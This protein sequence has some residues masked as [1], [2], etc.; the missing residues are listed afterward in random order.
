M[1]KTIRQRKSVKRPTKKRPAVKKRPT[2]KSGDGPHFII[3]PH[4]DGIIDLPK[5]GQCPVP[6]SVDVCTDFNSAVNLLREFAT[7]GCSPQ[8][9]TPVLS[10]VIYGPSGVGKTSLAANFGPDTIVIDS[11]TGI[12]NLC[13]HH[14]CSE[15]YN[16]DWSDRGF[17]AFQQGPSTA[18]TRY[19]E[20]EFLSALNDCVFAGFNVLLIA[21]SEIKRYEDPEGPA[22]E[23]FV[24]T[25]NKR[26]W[27]PIHRWTKLILFYNY[28]VTIHK[29]GAISKPKPDLDTEE[30]M[31]F[32]VH[33]AAYDAKNRFG[34]PSAIPAGMS[35]TEAH[36]ALMEAYQSCIK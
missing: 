28:T 4:E 22:Y 16:D 7:E 25:L 12:E 20:P 26:L 5:F 2:R 27:L 14:T 33:S 24:P 31:M 19:W 17:F 23:R 34:L 11:L 32:T 13:F 36:Q 21:H 15:E 29:E 18:A 8:D 35:G 30:R 1:A 3:D 10:A 6:S 9:D